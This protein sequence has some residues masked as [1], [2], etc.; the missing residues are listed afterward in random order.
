MAA[1]GGTPGWKSRGTRR[2]RHSR[3]SFLSRSFALLLVLGDL[4]SMTCCVDER[5]RIRGLAVWCASQETLCD[6]I[7]GN[8]RTGRRKSMAHN[9]E[10]PGS[11]ATDSRASQDFTGFADWAA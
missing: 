8:M 7:S 5:S 3:S 6:D 11:V 2:L 10:A 9:S 4:R 1:G